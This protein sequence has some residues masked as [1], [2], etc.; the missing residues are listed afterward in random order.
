MAGSGHLL[1]RLLLLTTALLAAWAVWGISGLPPRATIAPV[2]RPAPGDPVIVRGVY[3][4]HSRESD[5]T[6]TVAEIAA[7]AGRAGLQF[8]ILTD[9]LDG[10]RPEPPPHYE[11]HVL[12][13]EALEISSAPGHYVA[14][15]LTQSPYP[16]AGEARDVVEDVRRLGGFGIAAHPDSPR[17]SLRWD[18]RQRDVDGIEWFNADSQ[19]RSQPLPLL[20]RAIPEYPIRPPETVASLFTRPDV[21][22]ARWD[23]LTRTRRVVG[24][25]AADAHARFGIGGGSDP[26]EG[27]LTV[28][29]PSYEAVFRAMSLSVELDGSLTGNAAADAARLLASVRRGH[30]YTVIDGYR[31]PGWLSFE[32]RSG[33]EVAREGDV[34]PVRGVVTLRAE[35]DAPAGSAISLIRDGQRVMTTEGPVLEWTSQGAEDAPPQ[36]G[37]FRVEVQVAGRRASQAVPW[38]VSNPI[39]VGMD[40][41][42]PMAASPPPTAQ[43]TF[44]DAP[45]LTWRIEKDEASQ[46][47]AERV[48]SGA[49]ISRLLRFTLGSWKSPFAA[50]VTPEIEG[51]RGAS[52]IVFTARADRPLRVS[53]QLRAPREGAGDRWLRSVYLDTHPREVSIALD[54]LRAVGD[55]SSPRP[56]R[57]RI[58]TLMF[59]VDTTN[60]KP[61][62]SAAFWISGLRAER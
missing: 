9:H 19:W 57:N 10:S 52:R 46:A 56:A 22:L 41:T 3:H 42:P 48:G 37:T 23:A 29:A 17:Q 32:G 54:D 43:V 20:L 12:V 33:H 5:G 13:I 45:T 39:Y 61:G 6:G 47:S 49:S 1:K 31:T 60:A 30:L 15:G 38:I 25:A 16:L 28:P 40:E 53:V 4:V 62:F 36:K 18:D 2:H 11:G 26:Y 51:L 8:V 55:T 50:L 27:G 44:R 14:L 21:T 24:I 58:D 7:A 34:L 35:S 59:V